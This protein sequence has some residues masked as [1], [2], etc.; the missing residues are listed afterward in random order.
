MSGTWRSIG[1]LA[2][3]TGVKVPTIRFYEQIGL[4]PEARRT[5]GAWR[6]YDSAAFDRLRFI[7]HARDLG[8]AVDDVRALLALA[9]EP[10]RPCGRA[11]EIA[12]TQLAAVDR[13][14]AQLRRLKGELQRMVDV[15][16]GDAAADCRVIEALTDGA[17]G[18]VRSRAGRSAPRA[19]TP[20]PS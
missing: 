15:C 17:A 3:E 9:A 2:R 11:D 1:D 18:P 16:A 10:D 12:R 7:K 5:D 19:G 8:F 13:K 4:M 6:V 14:I 20:G